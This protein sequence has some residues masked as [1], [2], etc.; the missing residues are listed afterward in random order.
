MTCCHPAKNQSDKTFGNP[1]NVQATHANGLPHELVSTASRFGREENPHEIF[2][3]A[4][5]IATVSPC[6]AASGL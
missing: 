6:G 3:C 5:L 2:A 4:V 1:Y